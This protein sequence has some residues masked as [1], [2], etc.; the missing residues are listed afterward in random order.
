VLPNARFNVALNKTVDE[1]D[2]LFNDFEETSDEF[3][4]MDN[5]DLLEG[6]IDE[7]QRNID[8][9]NDM[10]DA[11]EDFDGIGGNGGAG[12]NV[13][14]GISFEKFAVGFHIN[15]QFAAGGTVGIS[16]NDLNL[17]KRY[18]ELGQTLLDDV[19]PL[20][21]DAT[22]QENI[23]LEQQSI[24]EAN[25]AALVELQNSGS[26]T[27]AD[28]A[29]AQALVD[30]SQVAVDDAQ[31][32]YDNLLD[33][34][35]QFKETQVG[36]DTE[37]GDIFNTE[38]QSVE[39]D[40]NDLESKGRFA[41]IAWFEVGTTIGS[42]WQLESGKTVSAGVTLKS[43]HI[44]LF[45]YVASVSSLDSDDIDGD[46]YRAQEDFATADL[47]VIVG[48][49]PMD[50]WRIGATVKNITGVTIK[51]NEFRLPDGVEALTFEVKPQVRVGT[52]YNGGWYR[53]AADVDLTESSG[54]IT[55][56]GEEFFQGTQY[57]SLGAVFNAFD[58]VELRAG[59]RYNM[60][61]SEV[62]SEAE[63][64]SAGLV[65]LGAG[66]FLGPVQA[67]IGIQV[68]PDGDEAAGAF[69]TMITF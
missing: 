1:M 47:G 69:Q 27:D 29:N 28:I 16:D 52:S 31:L 10:V 22:A 45:D 8:L 35:D 58:F 42:K 39:F 36:I 11:F 34:A 12:F 32:A 48:L 40:T 56:D 23:L 24:L 54:P 37:F 65:T 15:T 66:L 9:S 44:E 49:D 68:S 5:V 57:A 41:A 26:A 17:L 19:R 33:I 67:D 6:S 51:S 13:A 50:K 63:D 60:A 14:T 64:S 3:D 38:T 55:A 46:D 25:E 59:Y 18:T 43:V 2:D 30:S 62:V 21:D 4:A 20:Y 53:L 61:S 7:L